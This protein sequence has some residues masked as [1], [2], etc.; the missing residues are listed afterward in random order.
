MAVS[1]R[2]WLEAVIYLSVAGFLFYTSLGPT[3]G[4]V[5]N[6][7]G[8]RQRAT[9]TAFLYLCLNV[10]ALGGGPVLAGVA[11]DRFADAEL[12]AARGAGRAHIPEGSFAAL[13]PGG[14]ARAGAEAG[15]TAACAVV[16]ARA[17]RAG[18][19]VMLIFFAWSG[20]HYALASRGMAG[21]LRKAMAPSAPESS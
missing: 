3:F 18:L 9:A 2:G 17:T 4:V 8:N 10:I 13:C 16:Q 15:V 11:M 1:A 19:E 6:V 14:Q 21:T 7:V 20:V 5:Q 12:R